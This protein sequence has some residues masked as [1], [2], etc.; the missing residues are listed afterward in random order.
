[1]ASFERIISNKKGGSITF[2]AI[3]NVSMTIVGNTSA[4]NVAIGDEIVSGASIKRVWWGTDGVI[5]VKRGSNTVLQLTQSGYM[6][7][8]DHGGAIN[9]DMAASFVA[10]LPANGFII[11]ELAKVYTSYSSVY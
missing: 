1:M 2:H 6:P 10:T 4:S 3:A 5:V 8:A 7:F 9:I 11:V